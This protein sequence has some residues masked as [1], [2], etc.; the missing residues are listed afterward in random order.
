MKVRILTV[1]REAAKIVASIRQADRADLAVGDP[2]TVEIGQAVSGAIS[3]IHTENI[4]V[5]LQPN[6][7][8]ALISISNL[9]NNRGTSDTELRKSLTRGEMLNDLIVVSRNLDKGI[10]IVAKQP[11]NAKQQRSSFK[12]STV[13]VGDKVSGRVARYSR[14]GA[15]VHF[16]GQITG[17]LHPTDACDDFEKGTPV[18]N[19][20]TTIE[21]V[22]LRVDK[23]KRQLILSSRESRVGCDQNHIVVDREI[24]SITDIKADDKVRG[25]VKTISDKGV[26]V[27]LGR[28][29][30][31]RVL[32]K[33]L[34]D[35]VPCL[36]CPGCC[37]RSIFAFYSS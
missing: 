2:K 34:F 35:E 16:P 8:R 36:F 25:F 37:I 11:K 31:A 19:M 32:I 10:V 21:G 26:F 33:E 20:G 4:V 1:D 24:N 5:L 23:N 13:A 28:D 7:V 9:A 6:N 18:P 3:D 27:S 12:L 22:V 29:V 15:I 14:Q 30:D 17:S